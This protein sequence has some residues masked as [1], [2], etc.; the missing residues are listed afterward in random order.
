M[1]RRY[2]DTEKG[3]NTVRFFLRVPASPCLPFIAAMMFLAACVPVPPELMPQAPGTSAPGSATYGELDPGSTSISSLH[4][5]L[6]GYNENDLR[7]I[8][9]TAEDVFNKIGTDTGLYSYLAGQSFT[10]VVY[11]DQTEYATKTKQTAPLRA[12][13][14]GSIVYTYPGPDLDPMLA[15]QLM[16]I[17]FNV[18]MA[19]KAKPL[20]WLGE[21][22]AMYEE[23]ARMGESDLVVYQTTQNN[24]LRN[25]RQPFS[26]MTFFA[27]G[28]EAR[29]RQDIWYLQ[30]ES[31]VAYLLKQGSSLTFAA[32]LS[33]LRN[34]SDLDHALAD[35]YGGKYRGAAD[36]ETSWATTL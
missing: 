28:D 30:V 11:K 17:V 14:S 24:K 20:Q 26:Q 5:T 12:V 18:Y 9:S 4:F 34:G 2:G 16:H 22:L 19:D 21:G 10:I 3:R 6:K 23:V 31:V 13:I 8:S 36:F 32:F 1:T 29:R 15:H 25:E 33:E 35:N 7:A 27:G